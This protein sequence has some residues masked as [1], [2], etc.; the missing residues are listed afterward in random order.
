[1]ISGD[2]LLPVDVGSSWSYSPTLPAIT[3]INVS[4]N[5]NLTKCNPSTAAHADQGV[6]LVTCDFEF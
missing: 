1:M 6:N 5:G 4:P 2:M 3:R